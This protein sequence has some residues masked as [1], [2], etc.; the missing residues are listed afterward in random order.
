MTILLFTLSLERVND[1]ATRQ[2]KVL[3]TRFGTPPKS[4][5]NPRKHQRQSASSAMNMRIFEA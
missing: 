2:Q 3:D 1:K 5:Q 4:Y